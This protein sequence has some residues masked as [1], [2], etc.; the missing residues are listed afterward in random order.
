[1]YWIFTPSNIPS[2][3][4]LLNLVI[5]SDLLR[6]KA[7]LRLNRFLSHE[8]LLGLKHIFEYK[9]IISVDRKI[10]SFDRICSMHLKLY[11]TIF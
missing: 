10:L 9:E 7:Y 3:I 2:L 5:K 11:C 4:Q 6:L 8:S 1:M